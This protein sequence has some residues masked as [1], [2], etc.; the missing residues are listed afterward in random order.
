MRT[1]L[2]VGLGCWP[3]ALHHVQAWLEPAIML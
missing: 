2:A 1:A 3:V